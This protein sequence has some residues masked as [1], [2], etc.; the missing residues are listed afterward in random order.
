MSYLFF[1]HRT[2]RDVALARLWLPSPSMTSH[3]RATMAM[4][5]LGAGLLACSRS[6]STESTKSVFFPKAESN[7]IAW[8]VKCD[9]LCDVKA[10]AATL[11]ALCDGTLAASKLSNTKCSARRAAGFPQ[12]PA[13]AVTDAAILELAQSGKVERTAFLALKTVT[14]WQL[15]RPLGTGSSIKT[16]SATPVDLPGLAPAA[17]QLQIALADDTGS[18]ERLFVCG[19]SGDGSSQCPVAIEIAGS[20]PS[21][22]QMA[23]NAGGAASG[24]WRVAVEVTPKGFV[25]KKVSGS[26]PDG[27]AGEHGFDVE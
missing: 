8:Q 1:V 2:F 9:A 6:A 26:V 10:K 13:S 27:L 18:R 15:A 4:L 3:L 17:V 24:E 11:E 16:V 14:G 21:F 23:A 25:A 19:L 5:A 7:P 12:L 20:K 22:A